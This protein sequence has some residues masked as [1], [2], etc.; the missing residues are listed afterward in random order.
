[1]PGVRSNSRAVVWLF[2][3]AVAGALAGRAAAQDAAPAP[4]APIAAASSASNADKASGSG[5]ARALYDQL[6]GLKVDPA[7]VYPVRDLTLARDVITISLADGTI[8]F[9][10][11]LDGRVSGAVFNGH[12]HVVALPRDAGERR[13]LAQFTSVPILDQSFDKAYLRFTDAT[14][15]EL[16]RQIESNG[17]AAMKDNAFVESWNKLVPGLAPSQSLRTMTD[18]LSSDPLP[19]F[20]ALMEGPRFGAFDVLYDPRR[21]EQIT[22]GQPHVVNGQSEYDVWASFRSRDAEHDA[23]ATTSGES[24]QPDTFVPVSYA[25]DSSIAEDLSISGKTTMRLKCVRGGERIV[26]LELSRTLE[27]KSIRIAGGSELTYFQ[28]DELG[29]RDVSRRGNDYVLAVLP[30]AAHAG[31]EINIEAEYQGNVIADAGN[32]VMFV[33]ARGAWYMHTGGIY[34][35]PF[36]LS[37]RWPRKYTLVATGT[38]T[39]ANDDGV[40]KMGHWKSSQPFSVAGFNLGEYRSAVVAGPP[41]VAIYANQQ[42]E[43]AIAERMRRVGAS[44]AALGSD[45]ADQAQSSN[46]YM[47]APQNVPLIQP[48][49]S[50]AGVLKDLGRQVSDSVQYFEKINGPFPF[51]HLDVSQIPGTFGQGWPQFVYLST[52]AFLPAEAQERAGLDEWAERESRE[53]MPYHEVAHQW[54]GNVAAGATYRDVWLE[55]GMANYLAMMYADNRK[56]NDHRLSKWLE[57]YRGELLAKPNPAAPTLD[58]AGPLSLGLRLNSMQEPHAYNVIVYGKGAW[59]IYMLAEMFR[60][61][62]AK[63]PDAKFQEFLRAVLSEYRF[64]AITTEDFE[65]VAERYMTPAMDLEGSHRLNWFFDEWVNQTGIPRYSVV[66]TTKPK[67]QEFVVSGTLKQDG[68]DDAFIAR[69]PIY[70]VHGPGRPEFLGNVVASGAETQFHFTVKSKPGRLEIDPFHTV[71]GQSE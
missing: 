10:Q 44:G 16:E 12:G 42:L 54:W 40:W 39:A 24:K 13:S 68:V 29:Q 63:D 71:L 32:G 43:Q 49:P 55:E 15:A 56:P 58:E 41:V 19:Y 7:R 67:G 27:V 22:L 31:D 61:P 3:V 59:V 62:S 26:P 70:I 65:R 50:P 45:Q 8:G 36:E 1:M 17:D 53:L 33:G 5:D 2:C 37:F 20:Y 47:L 35:V 52:L 4:P 30:E 46:P 38:N 14:A 23:K 51:D 69:V 34:F 57:H 28:N 6:N 48:P 66:F 25:V 64:R 18:W 9:L 21:E 60:D 11:A